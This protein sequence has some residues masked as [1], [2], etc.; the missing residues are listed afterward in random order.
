MNQP[1]TSVF[2]KNQPVKQDYKTTKTASQSSLH[3]LVTSVNDNNNHKPQPRDL[4]LLQEDNKNNHD[5]T[6]W[7]MLSYHIV[8]QRILQRYK[9][10]IRWR[11]A[12]KHEKT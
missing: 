4:C 5:Q 7:T 10:P 11:R 12:F 6:K 9:K 8:S 1:V 3:T 2:Y